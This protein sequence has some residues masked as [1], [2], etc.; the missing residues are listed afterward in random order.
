[1][2]DGNTEIRHVQGR[3]VKVEM[4]KQLSSSATELEENKNAVEEWKKDTGMCNLLSYPRASA[5]EHRST[6]WTTSVL[7]LN[8]WTKLF[9][10][11]RASPEHTGDYYDHYFDEAGAVL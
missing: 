9:G 2:K 7:S 5:T 11:R 1:M 6:Y 3:T 10:A 8:G 4:F